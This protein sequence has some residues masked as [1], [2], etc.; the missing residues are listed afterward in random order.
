[1]NKSNTP[2]DKELDDE[3]VEFT[4]KL[5]SR[6]ILE[7][8]K[9]NAENLELQ[10]TIVLM[11]KYLDTSLPDEEVADRI[12][13]NLVKEWHK[14]EVGER[15]PFWKK[16]SQQFQVLNSSWQSTR[17]RRRVQTFVLAV[18]AVAVLVAALVLFPS[19]QDAM[20]ATAGGRGSL[21]PVFIGLIVVSGIIAIAALIRSGRR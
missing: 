14:I 19:G 6:E 11:K 21:S 12:R 10:E 8:S 15:M 20:A 1:M 3:L 18:A 13:S 9:M 2:A 16:L 5:L 7:K 17:N 4:D